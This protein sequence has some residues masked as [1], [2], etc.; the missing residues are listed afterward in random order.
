MHQNV[1][2]RTR[3]GTELV[4]PDFVTLAKA[5]GFYGERVKTKDFAAFARACDLTLVQ[6]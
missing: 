1:I 5:H 4:N 6:F 2:I 3:V